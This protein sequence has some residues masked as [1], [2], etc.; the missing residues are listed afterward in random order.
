MVWPTW[1]SEFQDIQ[2][3]M[4]RPSHNDNTGEGDGS[5]V[6]LSQGGSFAVHPEP[7]SEPIKG[8]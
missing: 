8:P 1:P 2:S 6:Y 3:Y 4:T 5:Q 7:Y